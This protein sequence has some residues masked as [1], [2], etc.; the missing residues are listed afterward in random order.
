MIFLFFKK[1]TTL[2]SRG[3]PSPYH[4]ANYLQV[5]TMYFGKQDNYVRETLIPKKGHF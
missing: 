5:K 2:K 4:L 3:V 1:D